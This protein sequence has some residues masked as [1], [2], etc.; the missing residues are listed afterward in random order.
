M[1]NRIRKRHPSIINEEST[2]NENRRQPLVTTQFVPWSC[3]QFATSV[4]KESPLNDV[5]SKPYYEREW[6]YLR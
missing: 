2:E 3:K 1:A 6:R 5:E 4:M